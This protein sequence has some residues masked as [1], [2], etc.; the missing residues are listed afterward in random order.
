MS[1]TNKCKV[2]CINK[3]NLLNSRYCFEKGKLYNLIVWE[4]KNSNGTSVFQY[5][6]H[7][8]DILIPL[9]IPEED[10]FTNFMEIKEYR[11]T[12]INKILN[13]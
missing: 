6:L 8:D 11:K 10:L 2:I 1:M 5:G 3:Y 12:Q 7:N 9:I 13:L 4:Y